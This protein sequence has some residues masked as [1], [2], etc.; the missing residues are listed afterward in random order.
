[1]SGYVLR[2]FDPVQKVAR[3]IECNCPN[4]LEALDAAE[5]LATDAAVEVWNDRGRIA[6]IKKGREPS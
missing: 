6:S 3:M 1:M 5:E 2:I 4:D